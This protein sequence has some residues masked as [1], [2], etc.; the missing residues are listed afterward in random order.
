MKTF[1]EVKEKDYIWLYD[2][3]A[4]EAIKQIYITTI[5]E[6]D[7]RDEPGISTR[8]FSNWNDNETELFVTNEALN[9]A[10]SYFSEKYEI[11]YD[12]AEF[13]NELFI[14]RQKV[15]FADKNAMLDYVASELHVLNE[16]R[17]NISQ[18]YRI[19]N[20]QVTN[21]RAAKTFATISKN[22][23]IYLHKN[24]EV[25][26]L[27]FKELIDARERWFYNGFGGRQI[28]T[29]EKYVFVVPG[30]VN[31]YNAKEIELKE[32]KITL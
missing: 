4:K 30:E 7:W 27:T 9:S 14:N 12:I 10:I 16:K 6:N 28:V 17:L 32:C 13:D 11:F 24:G 5:H 1:A 20:N 22:E 26:E 29:N 2:S 15:L 23:I 19:Q 18:Y 25:I 31:L 21:S 3:N 8:L